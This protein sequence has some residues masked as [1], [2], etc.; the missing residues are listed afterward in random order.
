[1][2]PVKQA[3]VKAGAGVV[4]KKEASQWC[5]VGIMKGTTCVVSYYHLTSDMAQGN[6]EVNYYIT[7]LGNS[8]AV[9][10]STDY[11]L[12]EL[13]LSVDCLVVLISRTQQG[14]KKS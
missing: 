14:W 3:D 10:S 9:C 6:G 4:A 11:C 7:F 5:D 13:Y 12:V 8:I 1:M 2:S